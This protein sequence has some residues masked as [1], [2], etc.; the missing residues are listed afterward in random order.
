M[1]YLKWVLL[2]VIIVISILIG[3]FIGTKTK[4]CKKEDVVYLPI[5]EFKDYEGKKSY[6]YFING[7]PEDYK[8]SKEIPCDY[9]ECRWINIDHATLYDSNWILLDRGYQKGG[10]YFY[11]FEKD[12][13][14]AGPFTNIEMEEDDAPWAFRKVIVEKDGTYGVYDVV[15]KDFLFP[16]EYD[17]ANFILNEEAQ[18]P[19]NDQIELTQGD[20]Y[21]LYKIDGGSKELVESYTMEADLD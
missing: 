12:K 5:Y 3:Y 10:Y 14:V 13:R 19:N 2:V 8:L 9:D 17:Y 16:L 18:I 7:S 4:T 20:K 6:S 21:Y 11:D 15:L 1:R